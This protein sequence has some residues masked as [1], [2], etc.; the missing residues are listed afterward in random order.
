MALKINAQSYYSEVSN[1]V[2]KNDQH[3]H[4]FFRKVMNEV[5]TLSSEKYIVVI[6]D[7][8]SFWS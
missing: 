6:D 3:Q 1:D 2:V 7:V 8:Q 4:V 5:K